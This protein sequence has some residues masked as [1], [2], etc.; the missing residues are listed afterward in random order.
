MSLD[1]S[2]TASP[3]VPFFYLNI[4]LKNKDEIVASKVEGK[5]GKG[6]LLSRAAVAVANATVNEE[7]VVSA[8]GDQLSEKINAAVLEMGITTS[9]KKMFVRGAIVVLRVEILDVDKL[10]LVLAAKGPEF[11]SS[12][13]RLLSTLVDLKLEEA[14]PKIDEKVSSKVHGALMSK[15]QEI[16]PEKMAQAGLQVECEVCTKENQAECFF[17]LLDRHGLTGV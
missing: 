11:A 8:V 5:V 6:S 16:I 4:V 17:S 10:T 12:F 7:T 3:S 15:F 1:T 2:T 14:I 9:I 13:S